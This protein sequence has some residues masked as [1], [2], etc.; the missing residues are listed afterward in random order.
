M[1]IPSRHHRASL[2]TLSRCVGNTWTNIQWIE[3]GQ[4][5]VALPD[6]YLRIILTGPASIIEPATSH[7]DAGQTHGN[8]HPLFANSC[9]RLDLPPLLASLGNRTQAETVALGVY[10]FPH[11]H[12]SLSDPLSSYQVTLDWA[13]RNTRLN[14]P[15][16][17]RQLPS[18]S[19][20]VTHSALNGTGTVSF[21]A[22]ADS[23]QLRTNMARFDDLARSI[24]LNAEQAQFMSR[25]TRGRAPGQL[26]PP[27]PTGSATD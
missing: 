12:T 23:E 20:Y 9:G 13:E 10:Y 3:R 11:K 24:Q 16:C 25:R 5:A 4:H 15:M 27:M 6:G 18:L 8:E 2:S 7:A 26:D 1:A 17:W 22:G 21:E 14:F 19:E